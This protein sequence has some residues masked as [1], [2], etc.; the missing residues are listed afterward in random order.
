M[1]DDY[2]RPVN[3]EPIS[4]KKEETTSEFLYRN[5][6]PLVIVG[7]AVL[8]GF[9]IWWI[10]EVV[11]RA[12]EPETNF[13]NDVIVPIVVPEPVE[14]IKEIIPVVYVKPVEDTPD[15]DTPASDTPA[16]DT[17]ASDTP[18]TETPID[19]P[20]ADITVAETPADSKEPALNDPAETL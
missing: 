16:L 19:V 11:P 18:A 4:F 12:V 6:K 1:S 2:L 10:S 9:Q 8:L 14:T 13:T 7:L 15:S 5:I 17:P 20:V 3:G